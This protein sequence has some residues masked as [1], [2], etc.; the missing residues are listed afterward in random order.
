MHSS[1]ASERIEIINYMK[2]TFHSDIKADVLRGLTSCQKSI[3]SKYFY[4]ANG[5]RLF[6]RNLQ[7][8]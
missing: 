4:D 7:P 5:S 3:P 2:D 6:E 8:A 1:L